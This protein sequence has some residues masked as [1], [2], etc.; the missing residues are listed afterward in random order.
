MRAI[1]VHY[2][3]ALSSTYRSWGRKVKFKNVLSERTAPWVAQVFFSRAAGSFGVGVAGASRLTHL[4]P[5]QR[6]QTSE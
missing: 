2:T 4:R 6:Q 3:V 5:R 1:F